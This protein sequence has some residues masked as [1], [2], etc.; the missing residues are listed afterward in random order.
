MATRGFTP[1]LP[2]SELRRARRPGR[3]APRRVPTVGKHR[4]WSHWVLVLPLVMA[5]CGPFTFPLAFSPTAAIELPTTGHEVW[6]TVSDERLGDSSTWLGVLRTG[7]V[8]GD[9][10]LQ[11]GDSVALRM[12]RD[13]VA[14]LRSKGYR[15]HE[16]DASPRQPEDTLLQIRIVR[17]A[18]TVY[19]AAFQTPT[20]QWSSAFVCRA[21]IETSREPL[22]ADFVYTSEKQSISA[23][24]RKQEQA[25]VETFYRGAVNEVVRQFAAAVPP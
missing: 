9:Y 12:T 7:D 4:V 19:V 23:S 10:V 6:V 14:A 16:S 2:L 13:V 22:W 5:G 20:W 8:V 18:A 24:S 3:A 25:T 21:G 15:A 11:G 17:L 1:A